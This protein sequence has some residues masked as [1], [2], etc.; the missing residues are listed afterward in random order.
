MIRGLNLC[1]GIVS[2]KYARHLANR[3]HRAGE[4]EIA[5]R[6]IMARREEAKGLINNYPA[7]QNKRFINDPWEA[8]L[9][10]EQEMYE[11]EEREHRERVDRE[12]AGWENN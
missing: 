2:P 12:Q 7:M 6:I 11:A 3:A 10:A 9:R 8:E 4:H 1:I 5:D